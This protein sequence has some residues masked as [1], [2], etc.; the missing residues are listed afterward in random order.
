[1]RLTTSY[2]DWGLGLCFL[3]LRN[4]KEFGWN[5]KRV[6]PPNLLGNRGGRGRQIPGANTAPAR[7]R[8]KGNSR[9]AQTTPIDYQLADVLDLSALMVRLQSETYSFFPN[10]F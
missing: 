7:C 1:M 5:H 8:A 6:Y 2:R 9:T 3:H 10:V 4:V